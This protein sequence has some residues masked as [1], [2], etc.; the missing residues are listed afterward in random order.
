MRAMTATIARSIRLRL[1]AEFT[2]LFVGVPVVMAATFGSYSLFTVVWA[3]AG[4]AGA[5]LIVTPGFRW[6]DL[7][8]GPVLGEWRILFFGSCLA[9]RA[10]SKVR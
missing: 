1:W 7:L 8:R 4:V 6:R 2:I 9:E 3:L 5:L 10:F